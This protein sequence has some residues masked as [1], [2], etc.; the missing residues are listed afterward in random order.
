MNNMSDRRF[1]MKWVLI[2][3]IFVLVGLFGIEVFTDNEVFD[4]TVIGIILGQIL[5]FI[6]G[7][8]TFYTQSDKDNE[9]PTD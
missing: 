2:I 6:G 4:D 7:Y 8:V 9:P 3:M 5:G 1:L